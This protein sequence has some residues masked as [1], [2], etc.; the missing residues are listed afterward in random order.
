MY[1]VYSTALADLGF[2]KTMHLQMILIER[3]QNLPK[4]KKK[5][6]YSI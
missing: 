2:E 5:T 3:A 6:Q 1:L 4:M